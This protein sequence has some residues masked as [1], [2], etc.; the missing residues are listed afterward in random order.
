MVARVQQP[1]PLLAG[2]PIAPGEKP[3]LVVTLTDALG[4]VLYSKQCRDGFQAAHTAQLMIGQR[5]PLV[6]GDLLRVTLPPPEGEV[7]NTPRETD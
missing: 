4:I 1:Q 7:H 6:A 2:P 3:T 5:N